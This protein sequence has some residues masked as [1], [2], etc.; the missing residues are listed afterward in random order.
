[1]ARKLSSRF[2]RGTII[3]PVCNAD[4]LIHGGEH[5][6]RLVKSLY[7]HC[8]NTD[9]GMTWRMQLSFEYVVSPTGIDGA[10]EDLPQAPAGMERTIFPSG[11]PA[12]PGDPNQIA[13]F[14]HD[15]G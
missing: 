3:C 7:V 14:E 11:P 15:T 9:C 13:M 4:G 8:S 6:T 10:G 1:M 5:E 2:R 12:P